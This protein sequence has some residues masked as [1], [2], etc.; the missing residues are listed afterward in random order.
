MAGLDTGPADVICCDSGEGSDGEGLSKD[1]VLVMLLVA[2]D[3]AKDD[4]C[5][6]CF[7]LEAVDDTEP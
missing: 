7:K 4:G 2:M 1:E 5:D 6:A 3:G